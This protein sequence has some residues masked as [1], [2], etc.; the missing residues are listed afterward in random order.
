[1]ERIPITSLAT[2]PRKQ[3]RNSAYG[4]E[5]MSATIPTT[6]EEREVNKGI[7]QPKRKGERGERKRAFQWLAYC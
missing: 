5:W 3:K 7:R 2:T 6:S 1:M 4:E